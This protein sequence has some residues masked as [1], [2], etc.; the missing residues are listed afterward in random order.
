MPSELLDFRRRSLDMVF[1]VARGPHMVGGD[2]IPPPFP[3]SA[4]LNPAPSRVDLLRL[5]ARSAAG[6]LFSRDE[7]PCPSDS[8]QGGRTF[9]PIFLC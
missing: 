1:G 7:R 3:D 6:A 9:I 4:A 2:P 5:L 8:D